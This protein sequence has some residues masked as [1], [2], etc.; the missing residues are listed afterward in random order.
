MMILNL[1]AATTAAGAAGVPVSPGWSPT[2]TFS[3]INTILTL[4]IGGG[5]LY[6]VA[7]AIALLWKMSND[8]AKQDNDAAATVRKEMLDLTDRLQSRVDTL[9][10]NG[11]EERTRHAAEVEKI[12][13]DHAEEMLGVRRHYESEIKSLREE[14][15]GLHSQMIQ[16]QRSSGAAMELGKRAPTTARKQISDSDIDKVL[17]EAYKIKGTGED[18]S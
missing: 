15:K 2:T 17:Q 8:R 11:T 12:R 4:V 13:K 9:E 1:V 18:A 10:K 16:M 5:G 3:A 6:G 7:R 14:I